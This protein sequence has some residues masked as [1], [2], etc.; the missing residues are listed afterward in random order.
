MREII[1]KHGKDALPDDAR[2]YTNTSKML[3]KPEAIRPTSLSE[4][5]MM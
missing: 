3:K 5:Q 1:P 2:E 4:H